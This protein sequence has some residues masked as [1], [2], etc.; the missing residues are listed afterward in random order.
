[1][2]AALSISIGQCSDA[3]R[4]SANQDFYGAL[5]PE[6]PLLCLK[7]VAIVLADGISTS[8]VG[9]DASET[10]VKSFLSDYYC[11]PDSWS[12]KTSA[13]RVIAAANS[14]MHAQNRPIRLL[15]DK[16]RGYVC[17]LSALV[18]KS[19]TA[20]I[21]HIGDGR[22]CRVVGRSLEQLTEDH[23]VIV[24]SAESYLGRALG[25]NAQIEIDYRTLPVEEG[26]LFGL[27][28]D[29]VH[30]NVTPRVMAEA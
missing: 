10:A 26:D 28:S 6:G 17:T 16:D 20:H 23:R 25:I 27:A 11:T 22:I 8:D 1:M 3:G 18:I 19:K 30:E 13:Q 4:K 24:S 7:G 12:V 14:W 15:E 21:F 5:I 9:A 2:Q 29:G